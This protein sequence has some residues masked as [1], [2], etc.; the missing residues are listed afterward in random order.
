MAEFLACFTGVHPA[1]EDR[2]QQ[3]AEDQEDIVS[4]QIIRVEIGQVKRGRNPNDEQHR[5]H[6]ER[7][8]H[9]IDIEGIGEI[10]DNNLE[11]TERAG[12]RGD[13]QHEKEDTAESRPAGKLL[14]RARK[15]DKDRTRPALAGFD[16]LGKQKR[17]DDQ[18]GKQ[19]DRCIKNDDD[20]G[21]L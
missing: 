15:A 20:T 2:Q 3:S 17:K 5:R 8:R 7:G 9:T 21:V 10:G 1:D 16:S 13:Q 4:K 14:E 11:D 12:Q 19:C 6:P 18:P